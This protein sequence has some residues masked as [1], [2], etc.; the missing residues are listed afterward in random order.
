[1]NFDDGTAIK[2]GYEATERADSHKLKLDLDVDMLHIWLGVV[3]H[4]KQ[5]GT[6]T[7]D[8]QKEDLAYNFRTGFG[9]GS[10]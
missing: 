4:D 1:M 6:N 10:G 8:I 9:S 3:V 2:V 5:G 7:F